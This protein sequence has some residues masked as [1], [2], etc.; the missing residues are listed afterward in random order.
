MP[1]VVG[2]RKTSNVPKS[3]RR[4]WKT[5]YREKSKRERVYGVIS[6]A[7]CSGY[8]F[9][10]T[11]YG[12]PFIEIKDLEEKE[13]G[14]YVIRFRCEPKYLHH[15]YFG[16]MAEEV[17]TTLR[18]G[19]HFIHECKEEWGLPYEECAWII[20]IGEKDREIPIWRKIFM[21]E[22][23][24]DKIAAEDL[25]HPKKCTHERWEDFLQTHYSMSL[26]SVAQKLGYSNQNIEILGCDPSDKVQKKSIY[27]KNKK[28]FDS[29]LKDEWNKALVDGRNVLDYFKDLIASW[30]GEDLLVRALNEYGFTASLANADSDRVIKTERRKVTGEPDIKI[31]FE[32]NVRY[33]ELMDALSPVERYGQFDLRLSKAKN[34]F[35]KKTLFL[36]HGLADGKYILIDFM[37]DNLTVTYNYPN[38]RFGNKPCSIV[39]MEENGIKMQNMAVFWE[40]LKDIMHS[41]K[42][43]SKHW[44][45]MVDYQSGEVETMQ[46]GEEREEESLQEESDNADESSGNETYD[47]ESE[48]ADIVQADEQPNDMLSGEPLPEEIEM[49]PETDVED[50][51]PMP[52]D[53]DES[54]IIEEDEEG[55]QIEY[56]PEQ[57][58]ALNEGF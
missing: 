17:C 24:I 40:T 15:V 5:K 58:A 43:E 14:V 12:L 2:I 11:Y 57:W 4:Q 23:K 50:A 16:R 45:K 21:P 36:L 13:D 48:G 55:Q 22:T 35:A 6:D 8:R 28:L 29:F 52:D 49:L 18:S 34:Q 51:T 33:L 53:G 1:R 19:M 27:L 44:L 31:E 42:P 30:I 37:H 54:S 56:T 10:D 7:C 25:P 20:Q 38:P 3:P 32:G 47:T 46:S 41:T 39:R 26:V 9:T